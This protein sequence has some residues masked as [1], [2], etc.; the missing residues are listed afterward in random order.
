MII[1]LYNTPSDARDMTKTLNNKMDF[2]GEL[3]T[4][5]SILTPTII[6][7]AKQKNLETPLMYNYAYISD[8]NRY[9]FVTNIIIIS[10]NLYQI[11]LKV[12]VL[13]SNLKGIKKLN[14]VIDR[15][16]LF[17]NPE[18]YDDLHLLEYKYTRTELNNLIITNPFIVD[19]TPQPNVAYR[20]I[21]VTFFNPDWSVAHVPDDE[22]AT[23]GLSKI[24][25]YSMGA[26]DDTYT[27]SL[28]INDFHN[29]ISF[30][31]SNETLSKYL[32]NIM[33][34][35]Y[36]PIINQGS[37]IIK[38]IP[39]KISTNETKELN[40]IN[41]ATIIRGKNVQRYEYG[42]FNFGYIGS[43]TE[44]APIKKYYIF[45]PFYG[46]VE[47][48]PALISNS[49]I[50]IYYNVNFSSGSSTVILFNQTTGS[51]IF[52]AEC[53]LGITIGINHSNYNEI[54][55]QNIFKAISSGISV[56]ADVFQMIQS[57]AMTSAMAGLGGGVGK[58]ASATQGIQNTGNIGSGAL[59]I[60]NKIVDYKASISTNF[61]KTKTNPV[62]GTA[63]YI[64]VIDAYLYTIKR[65]SIQDNNYYKLVG[66]KFNG[67]S[68]LGGCR[69][70]TLVS[71][72]EI[73]G[74]DF[75]TITNEEKEEIEYLLKNG[76]FF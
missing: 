53:M 32:I 5:T 51:I 72:I 7:D 40:L 18:F 13:F 14:A 27:L 43:F 28:D 38:R 3:K 62:S 37:P 24:S 73:T 31:N 57:V 74:A 68:M 30:F 11:S 63:S 69:G 33:C 10:T 59:S 8:F 65:E 42:H 76:V 56:V 60:A 16:S 61:I 66:Y 46:D 44:L 9:Y 25:V 71:A 2:V 1:T 64:G 17:S 54:Y 26:D 36:E 15:S 47:L 4:P 21:V 41:G 6:I 29:F 75:Q 49:T 70:Y 52:Q 22:P 58:V 35:P 39:F 45:L 23:N 12:D 19:Y 34:L 67:S 48:D 50:Y 20:N 55:T